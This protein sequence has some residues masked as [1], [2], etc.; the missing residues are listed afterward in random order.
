MLKSFNYEKKIVPGV[1][2]EVSFSVVNTGSSPFYYN[3]PVEI[4][5]LD[6]TTHKPVWSTTLSDVNINEWMPGDKW[7]PSLKSYEEQAETF[8]IARKFTVDPS[9]GNGKYIIS[10]AVL[11][12]AGMLP[13]L[14]FATRNYFEGGRHPMGYIGVGQELDEYRLDSR[15][16]NDIASDVTLKYV[17]SNK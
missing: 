8:T 5:L 1:P 16:F 11:D 12:P 14:R 15:L 13:S 6:V 10:I 17:I 7:N 9:I 3:W 4:S 2:F